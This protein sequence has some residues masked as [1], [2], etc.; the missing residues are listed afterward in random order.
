[1]VWFT[2]RKGGNVSGIGPTRS[3]N[4][5]NQPF[6]RQGKSSGL[7]GECPPGS[8]GEEEYSSFFVPEVEAIGGRSREDCLRIFDAMRRVRLS[9]FSC[10]TIASFALAIRILSKSRR[11]R[12]FGSSFVSSRCFPFSLAVGEFLRERLFSGGE[13]MAGSGSSG[14]A[15]PSSYFH[16]TEPS[17]TG[18]GG[19]RKAKMEVPSS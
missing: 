5:S 4:L 19:V 12:L 6:R 7:R 14:S 17:F 10:L 3:A 2:S 1:M 13:W 8:G 15:I 11:V 18:A 9:S 16:L